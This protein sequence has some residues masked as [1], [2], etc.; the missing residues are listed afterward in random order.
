M[1]GCHHRHHHQPGQL[2]GGLNWSLLLLLLFPWCRHPGGRWDRLTSPRLTAA[3]AAAASYSPVQRAGPSQEAVCRPPL[4][5]HLLTNK[6]NIC[7]SVP[8]SHAYA[9][10]RSAPFALCLLACLPACLSSQPA[11]A[12]G[13]SRGA[14]G[15]E[16]RQ[17]DPAPW[18]PSLPPAPLPAPAAASFVIIFTAYI[19]Y[20]EQQR[21]R[22]SASPFA[23]TA[24]IAS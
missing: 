19:P 20:G 17:A 10:D 15:G 6:Q 24:A 2:A 21:P 1:P 22:H 12:L 13:G 9:P 5:A 4:L 16:A 18:T 8:H 23:S 7:S 11:T 3:A 14:L